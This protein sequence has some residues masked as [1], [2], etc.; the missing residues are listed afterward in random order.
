MTTP[1]SL[2]LHPG[3]MA[4]LVGRS[5]GS[6]KPLTSNGERNTYRVTVAGTTVEIL[7]RLIAKAI[8]GDFAE[9]VRI[10]REISPPEGSY[11]KG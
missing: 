2:V 3:L 4:L 10:A 8:E 9:A 7:I 1:S 5:S 6:L 11:R